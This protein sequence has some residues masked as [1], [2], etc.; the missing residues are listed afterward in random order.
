M[1]RPETTEI[2]DYQTGEDDPRVIARGQ[3]LVFALTWIAYATYYLGRKGISVCK[4]DLQQR[5]ALSNVTLGYIDT[6]Y[7]AAYAVGQFLWGSIGDRLG[8]RRLVG[9]GMLC[10]AAACAL[11]GLSA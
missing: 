11:F 2:L 1:T 5:F 6:G 3:S 4:V 9:F 7:L 8:P 10:A